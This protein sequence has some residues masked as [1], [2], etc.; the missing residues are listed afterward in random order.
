MFWFAITRCDA[1][2]NENAIHVTSFCTYNISIFI[3]SNILPQ[4][5]GLDIGS[6]D[7]SRSLDIW[8]HSMYHTSSAHLHISHAVATYNST[9]NY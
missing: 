5:Q 3:D 7:A 8:A 9:G 2:S 4:M 1:G 6:C